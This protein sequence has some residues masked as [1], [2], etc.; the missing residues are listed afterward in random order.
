M[1]SVLGGDGAS[2]LVPTLLKTS[3]WGP[4]SLSTTPS[5]HHENENAEK[6]VGKLENNE[7]PTTPGIPRRSPIQVLTGP[8]VA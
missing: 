1:F 4:L 7:K 8:N 6:N 3:S 2:P 5:T